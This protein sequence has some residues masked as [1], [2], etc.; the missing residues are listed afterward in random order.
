MYL[1][2]LGNSCSYALVFLMLWFSL[3]AGLTYVPIR[4]KQQLDSRSHLN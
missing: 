1:L 2:K 4:F 3:S